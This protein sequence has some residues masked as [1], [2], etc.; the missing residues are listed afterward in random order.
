MGGTLPDIFGFQ[1]MMAMVTT[2]EQLMP[3]VILHGEQLFDAATDTVIREARRELLV[4]DAGLPAARYGGADRIALL[5]GFLGGNPGCRVVLLL[6]H[7]DAVAAQCPRLMDLMKLHSHAL[8]IHK[9]GEQ[10]LVA[11]DCFVLADGLHYLHRF[12]VDHARFRYSLNNAALVRPLCERFGQ[13]M[14]TSTHGL[15]STTLGL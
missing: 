8:S 11:Q 3:D 6:H 14:E 13:I 2:T 15:S 5:R 4:F 12:H 10:S 9:T 7:A 1:M